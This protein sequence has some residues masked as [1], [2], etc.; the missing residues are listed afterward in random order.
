[1]SQITFLASSKPFEMPEEI[2][3]YNKRTAFESE[4]DVHFFTVQKL[5]DGWLDE[6]EGLFSLPYL[7]EVEGIE[8]RSFLTYLEKYMETGDV[9]E[10]YGVPNQHALETYIQKLRENPEPIRVN[11][12]SLTYKDSYGRYQFT[13]KHWVEE[14]SHRNYLSLRGV[15]TFEKF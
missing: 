7:Y 15:T 3:T 11:V 1:M 10:V 14:M 2:E 13:A 8:S 6:I 5:D 12:G 4:E 9:F